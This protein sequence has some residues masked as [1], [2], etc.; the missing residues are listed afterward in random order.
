MQKFKNRAAALGCLCLFVFFSPPLIVVGL[1][2]GDLAE[3]WDLVK[4]CA[5]TVWKGEPQ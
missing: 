2:R 4:W 1:M 3:T 5:E